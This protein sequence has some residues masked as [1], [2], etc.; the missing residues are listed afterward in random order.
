MKSILLKVKKI[1]IIFVVLLLAAYG[2]HRISYDWIEREKDSAVDSLKHRFP[3]SFINLEEK[4]GADLEI[5][6]ITEYDINITFMNSAKF[7]RKYNHNGLSRYEFLKDVSDEIFSCFYD[8]IKFELE[9]DYTTF[10]W[11]VVISF[12]LEKGNPYE[13]ITF[14]YDNFDNC[15]IIYHEKY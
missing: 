4:F 1:T 2:I 14:R 3:K 6:D 13:I 9:K 15:S 8:E 5:V 12:K 11:P 10:M 7:E